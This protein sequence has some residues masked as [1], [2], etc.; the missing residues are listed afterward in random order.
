MAMKADFRHNATRVMLCNFLLYTYNDN[1]SFFPA[2]W[3]SIYESNAIIV[4]N[5]L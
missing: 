4:K 3:N 2:W 5:I 1:Q